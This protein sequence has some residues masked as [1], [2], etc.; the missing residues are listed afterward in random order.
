MRAAWLFSQHGD[1]VAVSFANPGG[2]FLAT[3]IAALLITL[4]SVAAL[5][6]LLAH[7]P[8]VPRTA[9]VL[10]PFAADPWCFHYGLTVLGNETF[11]L[12]V[13]TV[14]FFTVRRIAMY[15]RSGLGA[16]VRA[17]LVASFGYTIKLLYLDVLVGGLFATAAA[18]AIS[19]GGRTGPTWFINVALRCGVVIAT[20]V[21]ASLG[22]LATVAGWTTTLDLLDFHLMIILH[23]RVYGQGQADVMSP[24]A[25][26]E[27]VE[28]I[29]LH[30]PL[31]AQLAA[32]LFLT[33]VVIRRRH[34]SGT[35]D[36]GQI[37]WLAAAVSMLLFATVSVLKHYQPH[38]VVAIAALLP[39]LWAFVLSEQRVRPIAGVVLATGLVLATVGAW[40]QFAEGS[41]GVRAMQED[42]TEILALPLGADE[43]RVWTYSVADQHFFQAFVAAYAGV[44]A[45]GRPL[46]A[47]NRSDYSSISRVVR[48]YRYVVLDRSLFSDAQAFRAAAKGAFWPTQGLG[49]HYCPGDPVQQLRQTLVVELNG[50]C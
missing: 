8:L 50:N 19:A 23:S 34:R 21:A 46:Q 25:M 48:P 14:L 32:A 40:R 13:Y 24:A 35:V 6:K 15:S 30:S 36:R 29:C 44:P 33:A 41:A 37:I 28:R 11:A 7:L 39:F 43:A 17:G 26:A 18:S 12:P 5:W 9:A 10:S 20:F 27:A 42:A 2:F 47:S 49:I 38:Y 4:V 31:I 3:R 16:L 45:L 1:I 22:I